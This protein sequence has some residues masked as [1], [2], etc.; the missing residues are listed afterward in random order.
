MRKGAERQ[1]TDDKTSLN[2]EFRTSSRHAKQ[3]SLLFFDSSGLVY[4]VRGLIDGSIVC[5]INLMKYAQFEVVWS[6]ASCVWPWMDEDGQGEHGAV[7]AL[8]GVGMDQVSFTGF[9]FVLWFVVFWDTLGDCA[10]QG[11]SACNM[12]IIMNVF[13]TKRTSK[14]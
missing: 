1:M 6:Q 10:R 12:R 5:G 11:I 13:R 7:Y 4:K 2:Q 9:F 14:K 3:T 8:T